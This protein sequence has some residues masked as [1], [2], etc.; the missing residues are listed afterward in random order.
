M[1]TENFG[2]EQAISSSEYRL[3]RPSEHQTLRNSVKLMPYSSFFFRFLLNCCLY[4]LTHAIG[5]PLILFGRRQ[6]G[7]LIVC[8]IFLQLYSHARDLGPP[9]P[10]RS[11]GFLIEQRD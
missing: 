11:S 3:P 9:G 7:V 8:F 10:M 2:N 4:V 6:C 5:E 1:L